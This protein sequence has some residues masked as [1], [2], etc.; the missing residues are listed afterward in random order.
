MPGSPALAAHLVND[1]REI[2]PLLPVRTM[3][4]PAGIHFLPL[5]TFKRIRTSFSTA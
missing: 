4:H 1:K 3:F 5:T 2:S